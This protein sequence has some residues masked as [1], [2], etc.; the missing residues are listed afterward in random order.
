AVANAT[1]TAATKVFEKLI[2]DKGLLYSYWTLI[3]L[4]LRSRDEKFIPALK[5][6][7]IDISGVSDQFQLIAQVSEYVSNKIK[8]SEKTTVFSEMAH[9]SLSSIL[10]KR[11]SME[12]PNIF[13]ATF[14][15]TRLALKQLSTKDKFASLSKEFFAEFM[16]RSLNYFISTEISNHIGPSSRFRNIDDVSEFN[17]ALSLYCL[18]SAK[19]VEEFSGGWY[20]KTEFE[21][22]IGLKEV[23]GFIYVALKK[24]REEMTTGGSK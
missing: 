15:D 12:T 3:Q 10:T 18:Q 2:N 19:I 8:E 17:S 21:K 22:G 1:L 6:K 11:L 16:Q 20:S 9:L 14:E 7:G 5:E 24:L 13:G 4:T 23:E